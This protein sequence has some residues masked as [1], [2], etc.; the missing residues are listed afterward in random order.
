M[1]KR[2]ILAA[3]AFALIILL[4]HGTPHGVTFSHQPKNIEVNDVVEFHAVADWA[5]EFDWQFDDGALEQGPDV[6]HVFKAPGT[7]LVRVIA[8]SDT[9]HSMKS[10]QLLIYPEMVPDFTWTPEVPVETLPVQFIDKSSGFNIIKW[11]WDFGDGGTSWL[12]NPVHVYAKAGKY[13]VTLTITNSL[14]KNRKTAAS[15]TA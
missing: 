6:T 1:K 10:K 9:E 2:I 3:V 12:E 11:A 5:T 14:G 15:I 7:A 13:V 8:T 4:S